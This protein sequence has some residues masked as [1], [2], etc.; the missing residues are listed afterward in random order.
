MSCFYCQ[1]SI[2][3]P[4][5]WHQK[6]QN[7]VR[8]VKTGHRSRR[9]K[10]ILYIAHACDCPLRTIRG[11]MLRMSQILHWLSVDKWLRQTNAM[12]DNDKCFWLYL[13]VQEHLS[14]TDCMNCTLKKHG[15]Q[16]CVNHFQNLFWSTSR[17]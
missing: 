9:Y 14:W 2:F 6:L 15:S 11:L 4:C 1:G 12:M 3:C 5:Q 10:G 17:W 7:Q 16:L 8:K 13:M